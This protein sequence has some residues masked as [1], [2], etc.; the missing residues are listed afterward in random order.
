ME[1]HTSNQIS[2]GVASDSLAMALLPSLPLLMHSSGDALPEHVSPESTAV[3]STLIEQ[4]ISS[5]VTAAMDAHDV[6][7]DGEVVGGGAALGIPSFRAKKQLGSGKS[8]TAKKR[9]IDYWDEPISGDDVSSEDDDAPLSARR[10]CSN[11]STSSSVAE[12]LACRAALLDIHS[13]RTRKHYV[14][15]P[16]AMDVRSFIF[17]ICHDAVLYQRIKELQSHRRQISRDITEGT[18]MKLIREE[19]DE[20]SRGVG[21]DAWEAVWG[22]RSSGEGTS[23]GTVV[24]AGL[25]DGE[26]VEATWPSLNVLERDKLW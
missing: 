1:T 10:R 11:S 25:V 21:V 26:G 16:T 17:P 18:F 4:Y 8:G 2:N 15:A 22:S 6:F 9:K 24:K 3:L 12:P 14:T 20:L 5:L 13:S 19:G 23:S 7:T